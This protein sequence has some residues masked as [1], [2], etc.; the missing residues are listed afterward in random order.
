MTALELI[1]LSLGLGMDAFAVSIC[2]GL[3]MKKSSLKSGIIVGTYFGLFQAFM[4]IIGY[5]FSKS[6]SIL[7]Q[8]IDHWIAFFLLTLLGINMIKETMNQ[9]RGL[10]LSEGTTFQDMVG[11]SLA[12]SID[13][14]AVGI[15]FAFLKISIIKSVIIIGVLTFLLSFLGVFIGNKFGAKFKDKAQILGGVILILIGIKILIEHLT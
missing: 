1:F 10:N 13:A 9:D 8:N 15:T 14:L 11:V 12:T 2:K 6:F 7:F 5:V 3:A 4:P